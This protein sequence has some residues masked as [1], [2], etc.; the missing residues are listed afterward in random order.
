MA[1]S[2]ARA[3][4]GVVAVLAITGACGSDVTRRSESVPAGTVVIRYTDADPLAESATGR[5]AGASAPVPTPP[6][7]V[8]EPP[9]GAPL[10]E[11]PERVEPQPVAPPIPQAALGST[12]VAHAR[13]DDVAVR[14]APDGAVTISMTNPTPRGGP[15]V[16]AVVDSSVPGWLE[17]RLPVRPNGS[18]GWIRTDDV[19][20]FSDPYRIEV[21]TDRFQ[22]TVF[23]HDRAVL[24][25]EI[26]VG[27]GD[28]PT[29]LGDF[30]IVEL[31]E[32]EAPDELYG[33]YAF[34]LS[35]FSSALE[36]F[37][38]GLPVIGIHGTNRPDLIGSR[39]SLGCIRVPNAVITELAH[40]IPLGTPVRIT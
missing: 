33:P 19:E 8:P 25:T 36:T 7:G 9:L 17:V 3:L 26:G 2:R 12:L 21:D 10:P 29:P 35:G 32:A 20:L 11:V 16:F 28:S 1:G 38:G 27:K 24:T 18:T 37:A 14:D 39:V 15:R 5:D 13:V 31:L 40:M 23:E 6:P 30:F 4:A 22:L 34:G